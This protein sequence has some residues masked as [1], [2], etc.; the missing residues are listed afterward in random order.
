MKKDYWRPLFQ[1]TEQTQG[2]KKV[3]W[4][5]IHFTYILFCFV[6]KAVEKSARVVYCLCA[7]STK[8]EIQLSSIPKSCSGKEPA[9]ITEARLDMKQ[10]RNSSS[11]LEFNAL[12]NLKHSQ[13][14]IVDY[15]F[16]QKYEI[17]PLLHKEI[18]PQRVAFMEEL[19]RGAYGKVHKAV[20]TQLLGVE[21]FSKPKEERV[22]IKE[23]SIVAVKTLLGTNFTDVVLVLLGN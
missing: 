13:G 14:K 2:S 15:T 23:G 8:S 5:I 1:Y 19:G 17:V 11:Y 22:E 10:Q 3:P 4:A 16:R 9:L 20:M 18:P 6:R 7:C 21:V 12:E